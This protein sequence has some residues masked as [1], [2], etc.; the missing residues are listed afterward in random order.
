[1]IYGERVRLRAIERQDLP[2]FVAWFNDPEV[3]RGLNLYLPMSLK[4]EEGWYEGVLEKDPIERPLAIDV[5]EGEDW[6]HIGSCGIFEVDTRAR[7]CEIGISIGS[8]AYW[9]RG[10][11]SDALRALLSHAFETLNLNRVGLG[12][13]ESNKRAIHVYQR[14][15]F[16]EEGR[17][18][19]AHFGEGRYE[20][21]IIMSLLHEEWRAM[22]EEEG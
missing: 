16:K 19:Q 10:L 3:R 6:I 4:E 5:Q 9:D 21:V 18:R 7:S 8:R 11:G 14:L 17:L 13:F 2:R 12:V 20:D 22:G 15:G 1:V